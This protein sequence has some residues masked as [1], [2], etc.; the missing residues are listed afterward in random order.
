MEAW[1]ST[2]C[3]SLMLTCWHSPSWP[4]LFSWRA[5][6]VTHATHSSTLRESV[7]YSKGNVGVCVSTKTRPLDRLG[8]LSEA[9]AQA[10]TALR[11]RVDMAAWLWLHCC[12]WVAIAALLWLRCYGYVARAALL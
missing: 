9:R 12:S 2:H 8:Q 10:V 3:E 5:F 1:D 11:N 6:D 4:S 7:M